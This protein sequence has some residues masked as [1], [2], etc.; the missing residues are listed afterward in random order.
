MSVSREPSQG[1]SDSPTLAELEDQY[2]QLQKTLQ[3]EDS[4][5]EDGELVVQDSVGDESQESI[6]SPDQS[7]IEIDSQDDSKTP[8]IILTDDSI[9]E[10]DLTD[11]GRSKLVRNIS[12]TSIQ[13][14]GELGT[15]SPGSS[16]PGTPSHNP[17]TDT[18]PS[19][20][21]TVSMS[22]DYGTP[23]LNRSG[24]YTSLP[25]DS[26]FSQGIEDHIPFENLPGATG[27]FDR[28]RGLF[29]K[30]KNPLKKKKS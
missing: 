25:Q 14:F 21:G 13:T 5:L 26:K 12:T 24:S 30:L 2:K 17:F 9:D 8:V 20:K 1:R 29:S 27:S 16:V 15:G 23:I 7:V 19:F 22:K 4:D 6:R 11:E 10:I 3:A 18:K 28:I